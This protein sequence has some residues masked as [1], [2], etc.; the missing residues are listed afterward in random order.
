MPTRQQA[1]PA[2]KL[3]LPCSMKLCF[4]FALLGK[5]EQELHSTTQAMCES[6]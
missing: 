2:L 6:K 5:T 1:L 4:V 3:N